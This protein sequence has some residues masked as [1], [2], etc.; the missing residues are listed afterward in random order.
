MLLREAEGYLDLLLL[1]GDD[2]TPCGEHRR[3]LAAR[4]LEALEKLP[5][6]ARFGP[7]AQ[8][9]RGQ[10]YRALD[11]FAD[12]VEP[13]QS[14]AAAEPKNIHIWLA[15]GWCYKRIGRIDLAIEAL[16]EALDAKPNTAIIHYNLACYWSLAKHKDN[17][18][19]YLSQALQI[20]P[21]YRDLIHKERDFDA[22]RDDPDFRQLTA[23]FV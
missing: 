15:L 7:A 8:L 6:Q 21:D 23:V 5:E 20:D 16:Q 19:K 18:L 17:A 4:A 13:L 22:L 2:W 9:L 11:R 1:F 10:A 14:A 12:A 3:R